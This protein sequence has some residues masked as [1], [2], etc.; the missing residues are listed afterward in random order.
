[1]RG[2]AARPRQLRQNRGMRVTARADYAVRAAIEL[3]GASAAAPRKADS[4]AAGHL[5][6][7]IAALAREPAAW[8]SG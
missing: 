5:P 4:V 8:A 6:R 2:R 7:K 1:M 3:V